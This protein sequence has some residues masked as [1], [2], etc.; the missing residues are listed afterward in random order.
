MG[1]HRREPQTSETIIAKRGLRGLS[2]KGFDEVS[3]PGDA[4]QPWK[5]K[6][7]T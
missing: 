2:T 4:D 7:Y 6:A 3:P 1:A 5:A